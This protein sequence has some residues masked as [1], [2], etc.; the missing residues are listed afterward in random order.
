MVTTFH[1][2]DANQLTGESY[3]GGALGGLALTNLYGSTLRRTDLA[4]KNSGGSTLASAVFGYD[5]A[6]R[7]STVSD[8]TFNATYSYLANS[9]LIGQI[10]FKTNTTTRMTVT[11]QYDLLN[12]LSAINSSPSASGQLPLGFDYQYNDANQRVRVT[13]HDGSFWVYEYDRLGQ[14]ISGKK[15]WSDWTPVPGQQF[16]YGFDDIGNRTSTKAGGDSAGSGL[17]WA[18]YTN[19][20]LNQLTSRGVPGAVDV[21]GLANAGATVSVNSSP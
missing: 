6:G 19:N 3:G 11:R 21:L 5:N 8:G 17:R 12:R 4:L 1:Q 9:A 15:Y 14:V 16:E 10:L 2:N 18:G 20:A 7:L 13:L